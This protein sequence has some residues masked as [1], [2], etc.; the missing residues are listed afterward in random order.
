MSR[1]RNSSDLS[2]TFDDN[3]GSLR[4]KNQIY[5]TT[6]NYGV[7]GVTFSDG[8][9]WSEAQLWAAYLGLGADT[10]DS[11]KGSDGDD[12]IVGGKG[13]DYLTGNRGDDIYRYS[14]GDGND[15]IDDGYRGT[16]DQLVFFGEGLTQDNTV[17]SRVDG[18]NDLL[19]SFGSA[20]G[21]LRLKNQ[22]YSTTGNYGVEGVTFSDGSTW[23]EAQL[24]NEAQIS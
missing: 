6:G 4:L 14:L 7:E 22:I 16:N 15:T 11:L 19:I 17:V 24:W 9:T 8:S 5:S 21:S 3:D 2:I 23:S 1:V 18:T 10:D 12:I 20:D 13:N